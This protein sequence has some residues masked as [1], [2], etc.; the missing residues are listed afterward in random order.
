MH[1]GLYRCIIFFLLVKVAE[2]LTKSYELM[3]FFLMNKNN[4]CRVACCP[5]AVTTLCTYGKSTKKARSQC[6]S[7][8][9]NTPSVWMKGTCPKLSIH[10]QCGR[11]VLVQN[12]P[13]L[14]K[15][16]HGPLLQGEAC[17][18]EEMLL[19]KRDSLICFHCV[20]C[21]CMKDTEKVYVTYA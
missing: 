13:I 19:L 8:R 7:R 12:Y 2:T 1:L 6:W 5:C 4:R 21:Q 11:K 10:L 15:I 14:S 3:I 16:R 18:T 9:G 17:K 20:L